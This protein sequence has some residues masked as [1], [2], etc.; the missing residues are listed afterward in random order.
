MAAS[1]QATGAVG[2]RKLARE[3]MAAAMEARRKREEEN[4]KDLEAFYVQAG[5]VDAAAAKR[6]AAIEAAHATYSKSEAAALDA[7]GASLRSIRDRNTPQAELTEMTGLSAGELQKLLK[8][9]A[10]KTHQ[11]AAAAATAT[12]TATATAK[13]EPDSAGVTESNVT[14]L[15]GRT[16]D[17][18]DMPAGS[19]APSGVVP[20]NDAPEPLGAEASP[21]SAS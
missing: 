15:T 9:P 3:R 7:Q 21:A 17:G 11:P 8:R 4:T 19:S 16:A 5:R 14:P 20:D 2:A 1:K 18:G 13:R 12:A 6:D 10:P